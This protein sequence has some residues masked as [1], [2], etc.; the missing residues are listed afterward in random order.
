MIMYQNI[1]EIYSVKLPGYAG[2]FHIQSNQITCPMYILG[3]G[4]VCS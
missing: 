1:S 2:H 3:L 4:F